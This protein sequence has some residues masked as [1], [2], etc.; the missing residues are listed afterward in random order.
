MKDKI[1]NY[2]R[3]EKFD[4]WVASITK[5]LDDEVAAGSSLSE[6]AAKQKIQMR[7]EKNIS[8]D[9]IGKK[10]S[11]LFSPFLSDIYDMSEGEVSYPADL[12]NG[13]IVVCE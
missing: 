10:A 3:K 11:G 1:R 9:N 5:T 12:E 7:C 2:L 8:A 6:I 4:Y 13:G